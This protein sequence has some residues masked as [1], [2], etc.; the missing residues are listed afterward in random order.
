VTAPVRVVIADD[1]PVVRAGLQGM[2][3]GRPEVLVVGEA[4]D[5][6][7]A[8]QR[9]R[10]L[11]P[12]VVLMDLRMPRTDG[13]AATERLRSACPQTRVLILT[14]YDGELD[15]DRAVSAGATG[16]LLKD[17][18]R[19]ELF[20]AIAATARGESLLAPAVA[21]RLMRR[22]GAASAA[23]REALTAREREVLGR[24]ARGQSNK[25]IAGELR[26][27]ETTVKTHLLHIFDKLGVDD[28]TAAVTV[29]LQRGLL[30]L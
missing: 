14:T 15:I 29:A 9:C 8:V 21:A 4:S 30:S 22:A 25:Q 1:H 12:D 7:E 28:R 3:A 23:E 16:Y 6:E 19:E 27:G 17:S 11:Q 2:L 5:G 18:P 26:I 20:R 10:E 13:V 24:V